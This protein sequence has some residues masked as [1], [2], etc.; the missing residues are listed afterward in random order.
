MP[1]LGTHTPPR[2]HRHSTGKHNITLDN[3]HTQEHDDTELRNPI[4]YKPTQT[5]GHTLRRTSQ[6]Q[7]THT[8]RTEASRAGRT[9]GQ[10][11]GWTN[12]RTGATRRRRR[13]RARAG[14]QS[15]ASRPPAHAASIDRARAGDARPRRQH[16]HSRAARQTGR[17]AGT[18]AG[19]QTGPR[20]P[21][22]HA[23]STPRSMQRA[24]AQRQRRQRP[25][26]MPI[27]P[28]QPATATASW[29]KEAAP[30]KMKAVAR[31]RGALAIHRRAPGSSAR[32]RVGALS[33][34]TESAN[35]NARDSRLDCQQSI[36]SAHRPPM[37]QGEQAT[38]RPA[39]LASS[40]LTPG[41]RRGACR[42]ASPS[43]Q[44]SAT[45]RS[46]GQRS[47]AHG[48]AQRERA[49]AATQRAQHTH[50]RTQDSTQDSTHTDTETS[51]PLPQRA[52]STT[53]V[54]LLALGFLLLI[55]PLLRSFF[56]HRRRRRRHSIA[57]APH[58]SGSRG[59]APG[60]RLVAQLGWGC[61]SIAAI[62]N[63][64]TRLALLLKQPPNTGRQRR[65]NPGPLQQHA[66]ATALRLLRLLLEQLRLGRRH[67]FAAGAATPE[68]LR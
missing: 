67:P 53:R 8:W 3:V 16:Q 11:D 28:T 54:L 31:D 39:G 42:V 21:P 44:R 37:D 12:E 20:S 17:R 38:S 29:L 68:V 50:T 62:P 61:G 9:D 27:R 14:A 30:Q 35:A 49:S 41:R 47:A 6:A 36:A 1:S 5:D 22:P 57:R 26:S 56:P 32:H 64:R 13:E 52:T 15:I 55:I 48:T 7:S 4:S 46:G 10:T 2:A 58:R 66:A 40:S 33:E 34:T 25:Q 59:L 60:F 19:K 51:I 23:R 63:R 43:A 18:Q 24:C 65:R 45:Q